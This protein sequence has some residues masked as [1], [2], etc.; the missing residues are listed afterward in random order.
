MEISNGKRKKFAFFPEEKGKTDRKRMS[1]TVRRSFV[2]EDLFALAAE[3]VF[4]ACDLFRGGGAV[5]QIVHFAAQGQTF[6]A[7]VVQLGLEIR[8]GLLHIR[9]AFVDGKHEDHG[10]CEN[11]PQQHIKRN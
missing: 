9:I 6:A 11:D 3:I 10:K 7:G 2:N 1:R 4:F 8:H 5:F